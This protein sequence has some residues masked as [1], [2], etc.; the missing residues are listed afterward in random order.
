MLG[1]VL[2]APSENTG[3]SPHPL[4]DDLKQVEARRLEGLRQP[5]DK[6]SYPYGGT[7][8][9]LAGTG[10]QASIL[11]VLIARS[12]VALHGPAARRDS[13]TGTERR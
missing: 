3:A 13:G 9:V 10:C 1:H 4:L 6:P 2:G 12:R 8:A 5:L 7:V 11:M